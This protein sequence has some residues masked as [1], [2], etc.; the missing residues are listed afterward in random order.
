MLP[1]LSTFNSF[2]ITAYKDV[3]CTT[4]VFPKA[5]GMIA[6]DFMKMMYKFSFNP[7][8]LEIKS[9]NQFNLLQPTGYSGINPKFIAQKPKILSVELVIDPGAEPN[10]MY[11]LS[12]GLPARESLL[13]LGD[14]IQIFEDLVG[15]ESTTHRPHY[16]L[17]SW[18]ETINMKT[19]IKEYKIIYGRF[20]ENGKPTRAHIQ[21]DFLEVIS[22][23]AMLTKQGRQS[24]DVSHML[25][26]M[27]GDTLPSLCKRIYDNPNYYVEIAKIN[28]LKSVRN[29]KV[30]QKLYFPPLK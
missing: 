12:T 3:D 28:Q 25:E 26:V 7:N 19:T 24:P 16:L 9:S 23:K 17:L 22:A 4:S 5:K 11:S 13:S 2:Q 20:D 27:E 6:F 1:G 10:F 29:L 14:R 15:Y 18:G 8:S 21:A 30:G